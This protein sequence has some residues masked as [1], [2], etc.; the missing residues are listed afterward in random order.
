MKKHPF[1]IKLS[2]VIPLLGFILLANILN[3]QE[4][5]LLWLKY[6]QAADL[7]KK[8]AS[9]TEIMDLLQEVQT[10]SNDSVI[11][12]RSILLMASVLERNHQDDKA[13]IELQKLNQPGKNYLETMKSEGWLRSGIIALKKHDTKSARTYFK[14]VLDG[15]GNSFLDN[16]AIVGL[17]WINADENNWHRCDSLLLLISPPD[18]DQ[19]HDERI[20]ILRAQAA[21]CI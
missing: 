10:A 6:Q 14:K 9:P 4:P 2:L 16:E 21:D 5:N 13:L 19:I 8:D 1:R 20:L 11:L 17:A 3:A 15:L 7:F 12:G 18:H